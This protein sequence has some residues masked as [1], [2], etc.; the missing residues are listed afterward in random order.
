MKTLL[1]NRWL[2]IGFRLFLGVVFVAAAVGKIAAPGPFAKNIYQ[3]EILHPSTVN[4]LALYLPW[5]ELLTGLAL[6]A[7]LWKRGAALLTSGMLLMFLGGLGFNMARGRNIDCGCFGETE[8]WTTPIVGPLIEFFFTSPDMY[9]VFWR[10][11]ILL[12]MT[13]F[14][15]VSPV[16][17]R[18]VTDDR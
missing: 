15:L 5:V 2:S 10:D 1:A 12:G 3:Y 11:V 17:W 9:V 14:V 8:P 6:L 13:V 18:S 4:L 7:G 16:V